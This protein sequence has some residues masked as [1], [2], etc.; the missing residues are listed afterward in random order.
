MRN[1]RT[2]NG[3][4]RRKTVAWLRSQ[5]RDCWIC[6]EFGRDATIDYSLPAGD[7][8]SFECDEL[9]PV[10]LGGSPIDQANVDAA[11]RRC[12]QWR[13]NKTVEEVRAIAHGRQQAGAPIYASRKWL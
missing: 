13:G 6:R 11:H 3:H 8:M 2:A 12:N 4:A 5:H 10:S 7:P 9:V 1:I